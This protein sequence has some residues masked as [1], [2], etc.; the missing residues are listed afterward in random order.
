MQP[1]ADRLLNERLVLVRNPRYYD[2]SLVGLDE[3][4]FLPVVDGTTV[5]NL[6]KTGEAA[7]TPGAGL[8]SLFAPVLSRKKDFHSQPT[9]GT[10]VLCANMRRAPFDNHL[11]RYALNMATEKQALADFCGPDL[12][13][14]SLL[15]CPFSRIQT[16]R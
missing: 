7:V 3:L 5:M 13:A 9:F 12:F 8:P 16:A 15:Y 6:Y 4:T 1:A 10:S 2:A 11:L 14:G